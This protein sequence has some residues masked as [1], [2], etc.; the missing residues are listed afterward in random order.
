M[1]EPSQSDKRQHPR[2]DKKV[3]L[4]V[5]PQGEKAMAMSEWTLVTSK[6]ISA[7]GVLFT[8]DRSLS[9]GT[10][11][12]ISIHFPKKTI[13]CEGIVHRTGPSIHAPLVNVAARLVG[14]ESGDREFIE[15]Y[16]A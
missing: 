15:R 3:V 13:H 9:E 2:L 11:L 6:N 1:S 16:P 10:P 7:G 4:K 5:A 12:A 14:F 8:Y